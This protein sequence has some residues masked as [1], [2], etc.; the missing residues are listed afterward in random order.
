MAGT[1][2]EVEITGLKETQAK[3]EKIVRDLHGT[4]LRDAMRRATLVVQR[5]AKLNS[6]VDTGRLRASITPQVT[7]FGLQ[8]QGIVGTNVVYAREVEE[9]GPV[10]GVGRRPYLQPALTENQSEITRII[11][12]AVGRVTK[13]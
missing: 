10:R 5:A 7:Q 2:L 4:P 13:Q 6:P 9:P 1:A 11:D 8:L 3:M 12:E